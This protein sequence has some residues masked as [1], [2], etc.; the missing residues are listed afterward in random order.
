[1]YSHI[2]DPEE[3]ERLVNLIGN[4]YDP[5][6]N[7]FLMEFCRAAHDPVQVLNW[8]AGL[9]EL[10]ERCS[11]WHCQVLKEREIITF[12]DVYL[13]RLLVLCYPIIEA[14]MN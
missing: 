8:I 4:R 11:C 7:P 2:L 14:T 6:G 5:A 9:N 13:T 10:V 3:Y 12:T 1:M